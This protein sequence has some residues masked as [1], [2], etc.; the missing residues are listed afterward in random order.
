M[1]TKRVCGVLKDHDQN[2]QITDLLQF[3]RAEKESKTR[4]MNIMQR[5]KAWKKMQGGHADTEFMVYAKLEGMLLKR[6]V[7]DAIFYYRQIK[8]KRIQAFETYL[9]N[10]PARVFV[11]EM[12]A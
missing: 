9:E 7:R 6:Q 11:R 12:A 4:C 2:Y 1:S 8:G 10:L 5:R 3:S